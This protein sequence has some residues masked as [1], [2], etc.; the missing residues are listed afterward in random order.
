MKRL[1]NF[2][3]VSALAL[4][5]TACFGQHNEWPNPG[6]NQDSERVYGEDREVRPKQLDTYDQRKKAE[7]EEKNAAAT[8]AI[9]KNFYDDR[10][11]MTREELEKTAPDMPGG[12]EEAEG[13][14]STEG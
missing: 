11:T 7:Y 10:S 9:R 3:C 12:G 6:V 1:T 13:E 14:A 8:K 5:L 4:M 2:L